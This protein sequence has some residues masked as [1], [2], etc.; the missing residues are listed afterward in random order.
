IAALARCQDAVERSVCIP[1]RVY[2]TLSPRFLRREVL[3]RIRRNPTT[4]GASHKV[5]GH[6]IVCFSSPN[7]NKPLHAGH[8]RNNF[9]GM[10]LARLL[11]ANGASVARHSVYSDYGIHICQAIVALQK[12]GQG[13]TPERAGIAGDELVGRYYVMFQQQLAEGG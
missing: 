2:L 11:A 1:P 10:A 13:V 4:Y 9:L 8:L 6:W 12:W 3:A 5:G 7:P